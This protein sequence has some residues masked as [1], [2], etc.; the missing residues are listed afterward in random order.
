MSKMYKYAAF[1]DGVPP[2]TGV[3]HIIREEQPGKWVIVASIQNQDAWHDM[4]DQLNHAYDLAEMPSFEEAAHEVIEAVR[5]AAEAP[6]PP[7]PPIPPKPPIGLP[8]WQMS[9]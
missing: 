2:S 9:R 7:I 6:V 3:T 4:I 1:N 5:N 8:Q